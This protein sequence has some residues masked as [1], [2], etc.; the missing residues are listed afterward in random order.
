MPSKRTKVVAACAIRIVQC[1]LRM[2]HILN[3][4][5]IEL[6]MSLQNLSCFFCFNLLF[7]LF[8]L[9]SSLIP[10]CIAFALFGDWVQLYSGAGA[11]AGVCQQMT[12]IL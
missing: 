5:S 8:L 3:Y 4:L 9:C 2:T 10:I 12:F 6:S 7:L 11:G 1:A